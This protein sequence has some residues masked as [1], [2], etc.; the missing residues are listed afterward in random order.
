VSIE[1]ERELC[2]VG[3]VRRQLHESGAGPSRTFLL[4]HQIAELET[5]L[6]HK[7]R[8][9]EVVQ[10]LSQRLTL[11]MRRVNDRLSAVRESPPT[12]TRSPALYR[13]LKDGKT[14][15]AQDGRVIRPDEVVSPPTPGEVVFVV[16]CVSVEDVERL[17]DAIE[18]DM[19]VRFTRFD[20]L[21]RLE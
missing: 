3:D 14:V 9:L 6:C 20:I 16:D 17:P 19:V 18:C 7:R 4:G 5:Q 2:D 21:M 12:P 10:M 1:T 8:E 11:I 13:E 15:L